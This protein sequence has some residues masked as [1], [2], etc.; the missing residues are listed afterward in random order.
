MC[1]KHLQ[2]GICSAINGWGYGLPLPPESCSQPCSLLR[3]LHPLATLNAEDGAV[4]TVSGRSTWY[5]QDMLTLG[6]RGQTLQEMM[7]RCRVVVG[8]VEE[9]ISRAGL[10]AEREGAQ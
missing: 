3:A 9:D 10:G 5:Q 4:H 6:S 8:S 2:E 1:T 7:Q